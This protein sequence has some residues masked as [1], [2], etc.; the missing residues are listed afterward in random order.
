MPLTQEQIRS[1]VSSSFSA[2][3]AAIGHTLPS[4]VGRDIANNLPFPV[5]SGKIARSV[6]RMNFQPHVY[7]GA[8]ETVKGMLDSGDNVVI[9][10]QGDPKTQLTKLATSGIAT[11]RRELPKEE[12][13]RF[14]VYAH[15]D[16][17]A[18]FERLANAQFSNGAEKVF[19][20]DDKASNIQRIGDV[21]PESMKDR[22]IPV[23]INQGRSK[24]VVPE[25]YTTD[26]FIAK[27][28]TI[29]DIRDLHSIRDANMAVGGRAA[30]LLDLDHTLVNSGEA[31]N[32]AFDKISQDL[33][34][35]Q[36]LSLLPPIEIEG[37][38]L[39]GNV[40]RATELKSGMSGGMVVKVETA[41]WTGVVK[42]N[43]ESPHKITNELEGYKKLAESPLSRRMLKPIYA[44]A[45]HAVQ[46]LP[47]FEGI[48]MRDGIKNGSISVEDGANVLKELIA[49][50]AEWWGS[51]EKR[52]DVSVFNSMQRTEWQDTQQHMH[53][54][55]H[56]ISESTGVSIEDLWL[57]PITHEGATY[58]SLISTMGKVSDM[59]KL[60]P[61][62]T[63]LAHG[64]ASGGNI[65]MNP[66][67]KDWKLID[68]EW[69]GPTDPAEAIVR[70]VKQTSTT[71][72]LSH[73]ETGIYKMGDVLELHVDGVNEEAAFLQRFGLSSINHLGNALRDSD[74]R[75]RA[76]T[77]LAGSYL[78]EVALA[79]KRGK[80]DL[81]PMAILEAVKALS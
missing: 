41:D 19:V 72:A 33:A 49:L 28:Q 78:R 81:A 76:M 22:V 80:V 27:F 65:L 51:Q 39:N 40:Q 14:G 11:A 64:D 26:T 6:A 47:H 57:L 59:L 35:K 58:P 36:Y 56:A 61:S 5:S 21:L 20:V 52:T 25:G 50:K 45:E 15:E 23:W 24:N 37:V 42:H 30:W 67:T 73:A 54:A 63:V 12:K 69:A 34:S 4:A 60:S 48:Q 38:R 71:T 13:H 32:V 16:K 2:Q 53:A 1:V 77:Y 29:T 8:H 74:F 3:E 9:W 62:Y 44:S 10:T 75:D 46:V 18:G 68:A 31:R 79:P 70:M 66:D 7:E 17:I 55:I 43:P